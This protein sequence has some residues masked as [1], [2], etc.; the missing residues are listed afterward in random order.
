MRHLAAV[1]LAAGALA[2]AALIVVE[3]RSAWSRRRRIYTYGAAVAL[4]EIGVYVFSALNPRAELLGRVVWHGPRT[5]REVALTFDDGPNPP[6][7]E[8]VLDILAR[9]GVHATFFVIGRNAEAYPD[10]VR[11]IVREGHAIGSHTYDHP[12]F[13]ALDE[14][15][16]A[17]ARQIRRGAAIVDSVSGVRTRLF[18][19]PLGFRTPPYFA[20]ARQDSLQLIEWS[21]RALDTKNPPTATI[22]HRL[23]LGVRN[24]AIIQ[25]HDGDETH[26]GGDRSHTVA[27][28]EPLLD[29]L[30]ARGYRCVTIPDML[31]ER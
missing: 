1:C 13:M 8:Q 22:V 16:R 6:Y 29:S 3:R 27:A 28:V 25:M 15:P 5:R 18:R 26:H 14:S 7:T 11:R 12:D 31:A 10:L 23:L 19:P 30:A 2:W 17:I 9:R 4:T 20:V 24:G 21:V